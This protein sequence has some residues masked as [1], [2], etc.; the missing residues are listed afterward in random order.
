LRFDRG[1]VHI[2]VAGYIVDHCCYMLDRGV[3]HIVLAV[4]LFPITIS[5]LTEEWS[6]LLRLVI[7]LT[8]T[9]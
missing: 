3:V 7:L 4:I 8:I 1:A 5:G 6:I 9:V 2:A